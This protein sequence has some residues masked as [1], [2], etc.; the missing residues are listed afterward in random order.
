[1]VFAGR[2][3]TSPALFVTTADGELDDSE[4]G[5]GAG[6]SGGDTIPGAYLYEPL[7]GS[8][9]H[10]FALSLSPDKKRVA[11]TTNGHADGAIL[12]ILDVQ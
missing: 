5:V 6:A 11:A 7:S 10:F 4:G 3:G 8:A 9:S 2:L 1:M 12:A